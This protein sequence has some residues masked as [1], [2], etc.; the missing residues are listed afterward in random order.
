MERLL[1]TF[2]AMGM[3]GVE[4]YH[5]CHNTAF[6]DFLCTCARRHGLIE[7]GGSDYHGRPQGATLGFIGPGTPVPEGVFSDIT[8]AIS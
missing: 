7:T 1:T 8:N 4:V 3:A 5:H 6:I 2:K